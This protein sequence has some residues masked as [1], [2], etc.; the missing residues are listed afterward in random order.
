MKMERMMRRIKNVSMIFLLAVGMSIMMM[1]P[2]IAQQTLN[3]KA[4]WNPNPEPD[5]AGYYFFRDTS[6]AQAWQGGGVWGVDQSNPLA[7]PVS[8]QLLLFTT[9]VP[10]TPETGTLRFAMKAFDTNANV[11]ILSPASTYIYNI[12]VTPPSAPTG[13]TITKQ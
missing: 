6:T 9:S 7:L 5:I 12:D 1:Q 10:D 8:P 4:V 13:L 2:A 11:S 3:L